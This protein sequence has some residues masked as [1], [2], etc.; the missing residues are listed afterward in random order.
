MRK[1]L[2]DLVAE[3]RARGEAEDLDWPHVILETDPETG[4][5]QVVGPYP[6]AFTPRAAS[7]G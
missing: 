7:S 4:H 2:A 5:R 1:V 3:V 6:D